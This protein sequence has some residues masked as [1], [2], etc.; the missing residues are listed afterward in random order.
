MDLMIS[1]VLCIVGGFG[2]G[3]FTTFMAGGFE[4]TP[5]LSKCDPADTPDSLEI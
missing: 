1:I 2:I 5:D 3:T 4:A